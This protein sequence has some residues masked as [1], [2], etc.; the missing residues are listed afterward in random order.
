MYIYVYH[1]LSRCRC[2]YTNIYLSINLSM[3]IIYLNGLNK[4]WFFFRFHIDTKFL[5]LFKLSVTHEYYLN[6][7]CSEATWIWARNVRLSVR[8]VI[9]WETWISRLLLKTGG[10]VF[11]L[12]RFSSLKSI[13]YIIHLVRWSIGETY[14]HISVLYLFTLNRN[15]I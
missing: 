9:I 5:L 8:P 2:I 3:N 14:I 6:I 15:S 11:F 12:W 1:C 10:W 13:R 4:S 7:F